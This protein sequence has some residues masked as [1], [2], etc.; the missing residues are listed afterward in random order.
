VTEPDPVLSDPTRERLYQAAHSCPWCVRPVRV[1]VYATVVL[2]V[3]LAAAVVG[4]VFAQWW[5]FP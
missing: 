5:A 2:A 1:L 3:I 4:W